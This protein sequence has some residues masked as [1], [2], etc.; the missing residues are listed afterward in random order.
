[1][2]GLKFVAGIVV[3]VAMALIAGRSFAA[4]APMRPEGTQA[5]L[6]IEYLYNDFRHVDEVVEFASFHE[7]APGE[8]L[9]NL[10]FR[11]GEGKPV[12][13]QRHKNFVAA[14]IT[15]YINFPSPGTYRF[16]IRSNDGV[17]LAIGGM[18]LH[19][20]PEPHPDRT[21]DAVSFT[22][23]EAGWVPVAIVYYERKGSW[24]IEL[25]WQQDGEF[26]AVPASHFAH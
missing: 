15:G 17:R 11:G 21:S 26:N 13:N 6:S 24:A 12:L 16:K 22:A 10:D 1:M 5:G 2:I 7:S 25:S 19:E 8:P 23:R 4:D 20:D 18:T 14:M 9:P 3:A